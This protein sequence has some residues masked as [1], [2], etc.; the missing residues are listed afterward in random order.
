MNRLDAKQN[1]VFPKS[2]TDKKLDD[3]VKYWKK[4]ADKLLQLSSY[5]NNQWSQY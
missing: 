2:P 1:Q 5:N 3:K 4:N